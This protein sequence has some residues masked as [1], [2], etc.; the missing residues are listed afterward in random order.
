MN[1]GEILDE[2]K[3]LTHTDRQNNYGSPYVNHKRIA[4]LWSVYLETEITPSQVALCLCLVKIARLIE[5]PDHED[6]FVDLAAYA[7]I[8]GEIESQWK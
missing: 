8:A 6:S 1:R 4:D 2:A 7:S 3:R 5:T